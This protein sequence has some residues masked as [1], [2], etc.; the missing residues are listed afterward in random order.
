MTV[1]LLKLTRIPP[2]ELLIAYNLFTLRS[3]NTSRT[4]VLKANDAS[5]AK[6]R[7]HMKTRKRPAGH[8]PRTSCT[9]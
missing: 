7:T 2:L 9:A 8:K 1:S 3:T 5:A 6:S 4:E